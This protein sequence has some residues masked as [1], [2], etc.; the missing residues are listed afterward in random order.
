V[1]RVSSNT[2]SGATYD[3]FVSYNSR[4]HAAAEHIGRAL[5][6]RDLTVFLDRWYLVPGRPWPQALEEIL[7]S[8][9][10]VAVLIGPSG[11]GSWQQ[12]EQ[13]LAL[14]RQIR[15]P[16]FLVIPVLLPGAD[17]ALGFLSLITWVDLRA[18]LDGEDQ[19]AVLAAAVRG[20]A[21]GP[22]LRDRALETRSGVCPYRGL[23]VFREEDA[24]F[25][26]GREAFTG[27]LAAA[28]RRSSFVTVV[29]ASGSGKSSVV[30]A[31]LVPR[32]RAEREQVWDIATMVPGARPL[33]ALAAALLPHLLDPAATEVDRLAEVSKLARHFEERGVALATVV[34]RVLGKQ[35]G[36]DRLLLVVD[37]WEE[38]YTLA[39][40]EPARQRFLD[41]VLQA[42]QEGPLSVVATLR[43]DF[44]GRALEYRPLADRLAPGL[45]T[46]G[47]MT[48][49][50]LSTA[51]EAPAT[52][53][54]L[55]FDT[56]LV[57]EIL[58]DVE[59][60]PGQL[61]LLEFVLTG[62]WEQR[63]GGALT[64]DAY[65]AMGGVKGSIAHRAD[66]V[67]RDLDPE[68]ARRV[69]LALV[70]IGHA[71]EDTRRRARLAE[72]G[73]AAR[74]L[75]QRLADARLVTTGRDEA[76][77]A[78]TVEVA[79]EA[80]VRNWGQL[81]AWLDRDREFLLWRERLRD[82][83]A[84][85]ERNGKSPEF[86]SR[87]V[88]LG[89][90]ER[91]R[92]ERG[93]DLTE[94][95]RGFIDDSGRAGRRQARRR[96]LL[97][98]GTRVG[99][100]L[101]V[102]ALL[103][104]AG[105]GYSA[106]SRRS[107]GQ[108]FARDLEWARIPRP[109]SG[110]FM[111]GCV[112]DD[113]DCRDGERHPVEVPRDFQMMTHEVT[114]EEFSR[115]VRDAR[116]TVVGRLF[117]LPDVALTRPLTGGPDHPVAEVVWVE[118]KEFCKFV[119]GRLPTEAEWEYAARGDRTGEAESIYPWGREFSEDLANGSGVGGR[120]T[121]ERTAPVKSFPANGF[122]LHDMIGNV[123][124]WTSSAVRPYPYK[125]DDGREDPRSSEARVVRGGS[126]FDD[127]GFLRVSNRFNLS[128]GVRL[129]FIGFRCAR[130][131][132]P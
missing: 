113:R 70:Q 103:A 81:R 127:P 51:S 106:Y 14:E 5:R 63:R 129:D 36:T 50:E 7:G 64:R 26:F 4:D 130:D 84:E 102:L 76:T 116:A 15:Q 88:L 45:V 47:P 41:E 78:E 39:M 72:L 30:R 110:R 18:R 3:V 25:F 34:A 49:A 74:P 77:G 48:R 121:W 98:A 118:A 108:A 55:A 32:L 104:A 62:L 112:P 117:L 128:P 111:M 83:I 40:D 93:A 19:L 123:W 67:L 115:F 12:R 46:L 71:T 38:L 75:V 105:L 43:G 28:V 20:E 120:D 66:A 57:K 131:V 54:G 132:S 58:D 107:L 89:E 65:Q 52:K 42:T 37:Q 97:V 44:V 24:P 21:P 1:A 91:W 8:C 10:A 99:L 35:P 109:D 95:E 125:P 6:A 53:V 85:W 73:D 114:V 23:R 60:A 124:E 59:A 27:D 96:R 17:P 68:V 100:G 80:L 69:F 119:G 82:A 79:H 16:S 29:G 56:G 61:P 86:L 126:W 31:G 9:R 87:G 13:H 101:L 90:S 22:A 11:L 2:G 122:G 33:E 92:S 94:Q